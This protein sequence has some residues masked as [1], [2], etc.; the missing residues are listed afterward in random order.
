MIV[1]DRKLKPADFPCIYMN[2]ELLQYVNKAKYFG[3]VIHCTLSDDDDIKYQTKLLY[4]ISQCN[5]T[6]I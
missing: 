4:F 1:S 2:K 3:H 6:K 5:I